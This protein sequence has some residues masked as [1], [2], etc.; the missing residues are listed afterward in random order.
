MAFKPS[1][2][3]N[4]LGLFKSWVVKRPDAKDQVLVPVE[5][6]ESIII[7]ILNLAHKEGKSNG[8]KY[9]K[10]NLIELGETLPTLEELKK[11]YAKSIYEYVGE[12]TKR[13]L[14]ILQIGRVSLW[15]YLKEEGN[16]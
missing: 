1:K 15:R 13:T 8:R 3:T 14:D 7:A 12:D 2:L 5:E 11:L 10:S 9:I 16:D 4:A 6:L